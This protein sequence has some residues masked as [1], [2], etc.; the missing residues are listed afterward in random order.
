MID[1]IKKIFNN[2][3]KR[4]ENLVSFL[5]ILIITLLIINKILDKD[6]DKD[7][8]ENK[9]GVELANNNLTYLENEKDDLEKRLENILEKIDGVGNV[10]VMI[11]YSESKKVF[12]IYNTSLN[13]SKTE[14]K[15]DSGVNKI[16]ETI[17]EEK[18]IVKDNNSNI[19]LE[20]VVMPQVEGAIITAK[21]ASNPTIRGNIIS[22]VEAVTGIATHKI[23]VYEMGE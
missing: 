4:I 10:S 7:I 23:Q 8:Y 18:E 3:E 17:N 9:V 14:E 16:T 13:Q 19:I 22:A 15:D 21:G 1:N 2:K 5:V 20:K 6:N 12:P 11:T